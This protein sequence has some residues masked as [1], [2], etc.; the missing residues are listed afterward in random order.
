MG[1][2]NIF[3]LFDSFPVFLPCLKGPQLLVL[4]YQVIPEMLKDYSDEE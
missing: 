2:T 4:L 3:Q 1:I